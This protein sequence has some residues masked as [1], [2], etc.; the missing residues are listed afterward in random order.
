MDYTFRKLPVNVS[1]VGLLAC[2]FLAVLHHAF[3]L[4]PNNYIISE[5]EKCN[6][7][8]RGWPYIRISC[9]WTLSVPEVATR[10]NCQYQ[11]APSVRVRISV[12]KAWCIR[13]SAIIS[14]KYKGIQSVTYGLGIQDSFAKGQLWHMPSHWLL[15]WVG[16]V[17]VWASEHL[18]AK[19][20][21]FL[22]VTFWSSASI[23]L[24]I[25]RQ[26]AASWCSEMSQSIQFHQGQK[27]WYQYVSI[28][29]PSRSFSLERPA[30]GKGTASGQGMPWPLGFCCHLKAETENLL[31]L[32]ISVVPWLQDIA[33]SGAGH[34]GTMGHD[35]FL[36]DSFRRHAGAAVR[37][38]TLYWLRLGA[39]T[40][41]AACQ[42]STPTQ[43]GL[44]DF[45]QLPP[46][47]DARALE[48]LE[49]LRYFDAHTMRCH[50]M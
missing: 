48:A 35:I 3:C 39:L 32:L 37:M 7:I 16:S 20:C 33:S 30:Y 22:W 34:Y 10:K 12:T 31:E 47:T 17:I 44:K 1:W 5:L 28:C 29:I 15:T 43:A 4:I 50:M 25:F 38:S 6:A 27:T 11:V 8:Q 45:F 2:L 18:E 40:S 19:V 24:M 49:C 23:P 46:P 41:L 26:V 14:C 36:K 9:P 21:K 13:R 42:P